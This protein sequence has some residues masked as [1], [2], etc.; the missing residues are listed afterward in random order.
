MSNL[1]SKIYSS[2][3]NTIYIF[4]DGQCPFCKNFVEFLALK[5]EYTIKLFNLRDHPKIVSYFG[6][7]SY[8]VD[9]GMIVT[10]NKQIYF[11]DE[12]VH[13][14]GIMSKKN[15]LGKVYRSLF[16]NQKIA[17]LIY[18]ALKMGRRIVLTLLG[19]KKIVQ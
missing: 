14:I 4:Y 19:K 10:V 11:A 6:K 7:M 5:E 13:I 18:P 2:Q 8:D 3:P 16:S 15:F 12:A 17:E 1:S 9:E